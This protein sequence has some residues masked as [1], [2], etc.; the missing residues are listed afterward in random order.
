MLVRDDFQ[1]LGLGSEFLKRL[2][3]VARDDKL[4]RVFA[5]MSTENIAMRKMALSAGFRLEV[6]SG[7]PSGGPSEDHLT[8]AVIELSAGRAPMRLQR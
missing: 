8:T 4:D 3:D 2:L 5:I 1:K 7:E 6:S